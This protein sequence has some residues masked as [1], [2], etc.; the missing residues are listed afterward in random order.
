MTLRMEQ[1]VAEL[2]GVVE[3]A[4]AQQDALAAAVERGREALGRWAADPAEANA[5]I[6]ERMKESAAPFA[7]A[8]EESPLLRKAAPPRPPVTVVAADGS[9]IEPDRFAPVSCYV[10]NVGFVSLPYG[11]TGPVV[12]QSEAV[13]GPREPIVAGE[14]DGSDGVEGRGMGVNLARD[15]GELE[16]VQTLAA[17]VEPPGPVVALLDG[18]L[19]PW[20]LDSRAVAAAVRKDLARRTRDALDALRWL[21]P[22][23]SLG[24]Y[25]SGSRSAEVVTSL[26]V[27]AQGNAPLGLSDGQFFGGLLAEGERSALFASGSGRSEQVE[28]QFENHQV[29]AFYLKV[30][31]D[32]ARVEL[33]GWAGGEPEVDRLHATLLDQCAR[34]GGGYPRALQ[35]AHEQAVITGRDRVQF[36]NHLE[37]EALRFGIPPTGA[38]KQTSKRRRAV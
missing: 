20:D 7:L 31:G 18:T 34:C 33:P 6:Q 28:K 27:L 3:R 25:V 10:V 8:T 35:E 13:V 15:T 5:R 12:M 9:S 30:W 26:R 37:R 11:V 4:K 17:A 16:W 24:A 21:G 32:V 1:V 2:A 19:L 29:W 14:D 36:A 38:G 22:R 23:L